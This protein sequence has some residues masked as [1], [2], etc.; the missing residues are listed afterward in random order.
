[1]NAHRR[2]VLAGA[3]LLTLGGCGIQGTDVVESGEAA[4]V[5]VYPPPALRMTLFLVDGDGRLAP[6]V[7]DG[8]GTDPGRYPDPVRTT[9]V[10]TGGTG[11]EDLWEA[12][13]GPSGVTRPMKVLAA[14]VAGPNA[15]ERAAGLGTRIPAGRYELYA[16]EHA[17]KMGDY[18]MPTFLVRSTGP[19]K[20][21]EPVAVQQ[22]VCTTVFGKDPAGVAW[23]S[24]TGP[25]GT[26]QAQSCPQ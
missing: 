1:M 17:A 26:L 22:I 5:V 15:R 2:T 23:V 18:G 19:V 25:D 3:L 20:T 7:R 24:L 10:A 8:Q 12:E 6:V 4:S 16:S 21:L 14:L 9:P 11:A 13:L